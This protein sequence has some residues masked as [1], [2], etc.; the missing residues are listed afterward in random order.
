MGAEVA[1]QAARTGSMAKQGGGIRGSMGK[2]QLKLEKRSR[3]LRRGEITPKKLEI[4]EKLEKVQGD[5]CDEE[6]KLLKILERSILG[7]L[8]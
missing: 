2:R 5:Y 1:K 7:G 6:M 4:G 3:W 8:R